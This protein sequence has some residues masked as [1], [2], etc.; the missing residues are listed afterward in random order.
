MKTKRAGVTEMDLRYTFHEVPEDYDQWRPSYVSRLYEDL[1]EYCQISS[2]SRVLEIGIGTGQATPPVLE[3]GCRLTAVEIG[4]ATAAFCAKKFQGCKNLEILN[5]AFEDDPCPDGFYDLIYSASAFHWIPGE[6]GYPRVCRMLKSGGAFARFAN[7]PYKDKG[8]E[9]LHLALQEV[10]AEF[11]PGARNPAEYTQEHCRK[12]SD[13]LKS[14]G[15]SDVQ[16]KLYHRVRT[17]DA[18]SYVSLLGTYSDHR[19]LPEDRR[20]AFFKEIKA[21]INRFGG[22][23]HVYDTLDLHLAQKSGCV[24]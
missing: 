4:G 9:P 6:V 13:E 8:N 7:H 17:F 15:F 2:S 22:K 24:G 14:C 12:I 18:Q 1:F 3:T 5:M 16:Y 20:I 19:A 10:Y 11:M 23:I 21:T